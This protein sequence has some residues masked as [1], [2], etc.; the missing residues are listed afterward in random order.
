MK[1]RK[2]KSKFDFFSRLLFIETPE[3]AQENMFIM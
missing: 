3:T 2:K 1:K